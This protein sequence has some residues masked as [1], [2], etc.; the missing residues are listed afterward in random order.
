MQRIRQTKRAY[1]LIYTNENGDAS[2]ASKMD[3][4]LICV[5]EYI[6]T[7]NYVHILIGFDEDKLYMDYDTP[8]RGMICYDVTM[9]NPDKSPGVVKKTRQSLNHYKRNKYL[10]NITEKQY[11]RTRK[12]LE[13]R[14]GL[15]FNSWGFGWNHIPFLRWCPCEMSGS[16]YCAELIADALAYSKVINLSETVTVTRDASR[17]CCCLCRKK[18]AEVI[19]KIPYSYQL[20]VGLLMDIIQEQTDVAPLSTETNANDYC[21]PRK[22]ESVSMSRL[23]IQNEFRASQRMLSVKTGQPPPKKRYRKKKSHRRHQRRLFT[24]I[25]AVTSPLNEEN[26]KD[27]VYVCFSLVNFPCI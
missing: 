19:I 18:K 13:K 5:Q 27:K 21:K 24:E 4:F 7:S 14:L 11:R 25:Q 8:G 6:T 23:V 12:F 20:T 9:R 1:I 15:P 26:K 10:L 17:L 3:R 16:Y 22:T 2:N